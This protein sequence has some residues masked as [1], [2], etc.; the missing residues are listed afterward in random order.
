MDAFGSHRKCNLFGC[1]VTCGSNV[2]GERK[3]YRHGLTPDV[4]RGE[5]ACK[6]RAGLIAATTEGGS[7]RAVTAC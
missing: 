3:Q 4:P 7:R 2:V 6:R 1:I 5:P